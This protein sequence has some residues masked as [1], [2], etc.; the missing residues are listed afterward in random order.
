MATKTST[1]ET[2]RTE[3]ALAVRNV[4]QGTGVI[5]WMGPNGQPVPASVANM[6]DGVWSRIEQG[7]E[8]SA[9]DIM[10]AILNAESLDAIAH[11]SDGADK[12]ASLD[13]HRLH[14]SAVKWARG[15]FVGGLGVYAIVKAHD[16]TSSDLITFT[17]GST[18]VLAVLYVAES[19]GWLPATFK[20]ESTKTAKGFTAY[21]LVPAGESF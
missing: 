8:A 2:P 17:T 6:L 11:L 4:E 15:D 21:W 5:N 7:D 16:E 10:D 19:R 12:V 14:V 9:L 20:V 1:N 3:S 18:N 13:G